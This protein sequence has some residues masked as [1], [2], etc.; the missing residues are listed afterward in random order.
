MCSLSYLN[1]K[2]VSQLYI[3]FYEYIE[4]LQFIYV[5]TDIYH[6]LTIQHLISR[7]FAIIDNTY[8]V[9]KSRNWPFGLTRI[10][11]SLSI[12]HLLPLE[13]PL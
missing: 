10:K 6:T 2:A 8:S 11:N 13:E 3:T 12:N 5:Y 1:Y 4:S 9:H 7:E